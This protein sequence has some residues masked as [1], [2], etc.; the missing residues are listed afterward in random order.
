MQLDLFAD[1][2]LKPTIALARG[3]SFLAQCHGCGTLVCVPAALPSTLD[4]CPSCGVTRW[5]RQRYAGPFSFPAR[6]D[7]RPAD[8]RCEETSFLWGEGVRPLGHHRCVLPAHHIESGDPGESCMFV[9]GLD[10]ERECAGCGRDV[11]DCG[12]CVECGADLD[13]AD[14]LEGCPERDLG[15]DRPV[16]VPVGSF[17]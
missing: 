2:E 8:R 9:V 1:L 7:G 5:A 16:D 3:E 12:C 17:L 6:E 13:Q 11:D 14:H 10:D 4:A 15:S